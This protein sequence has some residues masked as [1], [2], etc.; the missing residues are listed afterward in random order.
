MRKSK[1]RIRGNERFLM[2]LCRDIRRRWM[3]YG[4]NR[5]VK[6]Q[7][8]K[9]CGN[10]EVEEIDHIE[11]VGTRPYTVEDLVPYIK[12]M[13]FLPCQGLCKPCHKIKTAE[14]RGKK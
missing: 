10:R 1:L 7:L 13:L 12:R 4:E 11:K 9:Q 14:Q 3:Q 2:M 5:R 8:C 6:E